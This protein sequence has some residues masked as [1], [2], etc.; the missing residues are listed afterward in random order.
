MR[1]TYKSLAELPEGKRPL[2]RIR[3]RWVDIVKMDLGERWWRDIN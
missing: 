1:N 2:E 3:S